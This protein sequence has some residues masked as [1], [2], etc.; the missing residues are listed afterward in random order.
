MSPDQSQSGIESSDGE[1]V[2]K[3]L[4]TKAMFATPD[5]SLAVSMAFRARQAEKPKL[6][7]AAS[8]GKQERE[9]L[10]S[11]GRLQCL[12]DVNL[13]WVIDVNDKV[14]PVSMKI[15]GVKETADRIVKSE[16]G[17]Q[18]IAARMAELFCIHGE[19]HGLQGAE[20]HLTR[21]FCH[22]IKALLSDA[23]T[24]LAGRDKDAEWTCKFNNIGMA[25]LSATK[26]EVS[27][28]TE[29]ACTA[30]AASVATAAA[31]EK[32]CLVVLDVEKHADGKFAPLAVKI[33]GS[34]AVAKRIARSSRRL[35]TIAESVAA[36]FYKEQ[37]EVEPT[38]LKGIIKPKQLLTKH[39][40]EVVKDYMSN[41][42]SDLDGRENNSWSIVIGGLRMAAIATRT[43]IHTETEVSLYGVSCCDSTESRGGAASQK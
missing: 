36:T 42:T 1:V 40:Q 32:H 28:D 24:E 18:K 7:A 39:V 30:S 34:R 37:L 12:G 8:M 17:I 31:D 41:A 2:P 4:S 13:D 38:L 26:N 15:S 19:T 5:S 21:N 9:A 6:K 27:C 14:A 43:E 11:S 25:K 23:V 3:Y 29:F 33:S 35:R 20:D 10:L 16:K 22:I